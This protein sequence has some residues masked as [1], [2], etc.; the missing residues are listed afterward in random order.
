MSKSALV[1]GGGFAGLDAAI[2]LKK[3][4]VGRHAGLQSDV[5]VDL[6]GLQLGP[7]RRVFIRADWPPPA[8]P[9]ETA[10]Q[11]RADLLRPH[12]QP[13]RADGEEGECDLTMFI[14]ADDAHSALKASDLPK[15]EAGFVPHV[16]IL[17]RMDMGNPAR[18]RIE[19]GPA[20]APH[21]P[22]CGGERGCEA[23]ARSLVPRAGCVDGAGRAARETE[24]GSR[25]RGP[26]SMTDRR[27]RRL[28]SPLWVLRPTVRGGTGRPHA[29]PRRPARRLARSPP[30]ME[31]RG[32][33]PRKQRVGRVLHGRARTR[34]RAHPAHG[35]QR[36]G[37][38]IPHAGTTSSPVRPLLATMLE[39]PLLGRLMP[40]ARRFSRLP[41]GP[42]P[43]LVAA[44][45]LPDIAIVAELRYQTRPGT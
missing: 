16:D 29:R 12:A 1:L 41:P 37:T 44:V 27:A 34:R 11:A 3:A 31:S 20:R 10:R 32:R 21:H 38:A 43:A 42:V 17:C 35:D 28:L 22:P 23:A 45:D 19:S 18:Q 8:A 4:G 7:N 25:L 5:P 40:R 26:E 2:H 15:T 14:A 39:T 24:A 13:R 36:L 9:Q 30:R 6:P 33:R